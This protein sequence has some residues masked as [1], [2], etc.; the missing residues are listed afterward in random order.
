MTCVINIIVA[1]WSVFLYDTVY[2]LEPKKETAFI[3]LPAL[4]RAPWGCNFP[5]TAQLC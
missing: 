3:A 2:A 1:T 4:C 5:A